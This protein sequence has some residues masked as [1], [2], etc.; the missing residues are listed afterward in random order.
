MTTEDRTPRAPE[1]GRV[2]RDADPLQ[3]T[4]LEK[5]M[6]EWEARHDVAARGHRA[7]PDVVQHYC[8]HERLTHASAP[9]P[10]GSHARAQRRSRFPVQDERPPSRFR[11]LVRR[12]LEPV[13]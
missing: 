5:R 9:H 6:A 13:R 7:P 10:T 2:R 4:E 11:A 3:M 12:L 1:P 8:A